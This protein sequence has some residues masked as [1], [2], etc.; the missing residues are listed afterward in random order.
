MSIWYDSS[1]K[2]FKQKLCTLHCKFLR[3]VINVWL[4]GY[5]LWTCWTPWLG[6]YPLCLSVTPLRCSSS[7]HYYDYWTSCYRTNL[8]I[9]RRTGKICRFNSSKRR[10]GNQSIGYH[11]NLSNDGLLI[12]ILPNVDLP[13]MS[14]QLISI[15]C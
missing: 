2:K 6:L 10:I 4:H 9:I 11:V 1:L 8:Y 13:T 12:V 15:Y 14:V 3:V 5:I 7:T